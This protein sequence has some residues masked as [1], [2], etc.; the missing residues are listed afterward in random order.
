MINIIFPID[1]MEE[2]VAILT[3]YKYQIISVYHDEMDLI[4]NLD[5]FNKSHPDQIWLI[6]MDRDRDPDLRQSSFT[7]LS[8]LEHMCYQHSIG[9]SDEKLMFMHDLLEG[10]A[11]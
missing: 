7:S 5:T 9:V 2:I 1:Q 4:I 11:V 3:K 6:V 8:T 10:S